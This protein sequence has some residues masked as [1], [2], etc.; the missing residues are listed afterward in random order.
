M[1][2][3]YMIIKWRVLVGIPEP[4]KALGQKLIR[5]LKTSTIEYPANPSTFKF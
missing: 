1:I 2:R 4:M 3:I 5:S